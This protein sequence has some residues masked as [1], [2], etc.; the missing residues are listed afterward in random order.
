MEET[1]ERL[2]PESSITPATSESLINLFSQTSSTCHGLLLQSSW[3]SKRLAATKNMGPLT[4]SPST[5]PCA[6]QQ[7]SLA[8]PWALPL[9][10]LSWERSASMRQCF[11]AEVEVGLLALVWIWVTTC[12]TP[13]RDVTDLK[14]IDLLFFI[15]E[16]VWVSIKV[17]HKHWTLWGLGFAK[18]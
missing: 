11:G 7:A 3:N 10:R 5:C 13:I 16:T 9:G 2:S 4:K 15:P 8:M 1:T 18:L 14:L 12:S 6:W 17:K